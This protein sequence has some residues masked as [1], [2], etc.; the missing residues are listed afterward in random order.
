M[1]CLAE[2]DYALLPGMYF[3]LKLKEEE[4]LHRP[5][6]DIV[7]DIREI[8]REKNAVKI[9]MNESLARKLGHG[10]L[11]DLI[12]Q[13]AENTKTINETTIKIL[14]LAPL[15]PETYFMTSKKAGEIKIENTSKESVSSLFAFFMPMWKQHVYYLNERENKLFV[16]LRDALLPELMSGRLDVSTINSE[17]GDM[18]Q[19]IK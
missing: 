4:N 3:P 19:D 1:A 5:F 12:K 2:R 7:D 16:E 11:I 15:E 6:K 14:D 10:E 13:S 9:T 18:K 17:I 8:Q